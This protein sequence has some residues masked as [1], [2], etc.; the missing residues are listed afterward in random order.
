LSKDSYRKKLLKIK[1]YLEDPKVKPINDAQWLKI[2]LVNG[3]TT[4]GAFPAWSRN[5]SLLQKHSI[6]LKLDERTVKKIEEF[7]LRHITSSELVQY[8]KWVSV[9]TQLRLEN[10]FYISK[11]A[12]CFD[13]V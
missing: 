11:K 4:S 1:N 13:L 5:H 8:T 9:K 6:S 10:R 12:K 3:S 7:W 2:A